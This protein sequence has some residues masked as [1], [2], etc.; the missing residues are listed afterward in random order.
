MVDINTLLSLAIKRN[1][2]DLIIKVGS[3][4][5]IRVD[6]ELENLDL[7]K[8][9]DKDT[10]KLSQS[11]CSPADWQKFKTDLELD[12]A[13]EI[14]GAFRA[15]VNLF[16]QR[17]SVGMVLR[18]IPLK[19]PT[20]KELGLPES[21]SKLALRPRGLVLVTGPA[22][23]GKSTTQA[24]LIDYRNANEECHIMTVEDPI[25]FIH[26]DKKAIVNQRQVGR[27][28]LSFA[29]GLKYVLRQDPDVILIGE[30]RD[31]ETISLAVTASETGHL[32]IGTVHTTDAAQTIDRIINAFPVYQQPQIR[33]QLSVNLLGIISQILLQRKSGRGRL[34]AYEVLIATAAVR[35]VIREAKTYQLSQLLQTGSDAGMI[36]MARSLANLVN[37]NLVSPEEAMSKAPHPSELSSLISSKAAYR[38]E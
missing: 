38:L 5:L 1:A 6:G 7:P 16:K 21:A 19:I 37:N 18:L 28:T 30:M 8:L 11:I 29:N 15:R 23:S 26:Q 35:N 2:S 32:A 24:A 25:E 4:P 22:G 34:A 33:M 9:S 36:G 13:Y 14:K 20:V 10:E 3:S 17:S 31:L 12:F 27:D